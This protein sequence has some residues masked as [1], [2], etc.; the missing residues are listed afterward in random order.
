MNL[1]ALFL[2]YLL[3]SHPKFLAVLSIILAIILLFVYYPFGMVLFGLILVGY[4]FYNA[5]VK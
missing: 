5:F 3:F 4:L 2:T 1:V